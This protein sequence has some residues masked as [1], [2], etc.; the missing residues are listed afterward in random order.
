MAVKGELSINN[1]KGLLLSHHPCS[2]PSDPE[3]FVD[4]EQQWS[5][6]SAGLCRALWLCPLLHAPSPSWSWRRLWL[7]GCAQP[8]G[9]PHGTDTYGQPF[10]GT[11]NGRGDQWLWYQCWSRPQVLQHSCAAYEGQGTQCSHLLGY[12]MSQPSFTLPPYGLFLEQP[13]ASTVGE[14]GVFLRALMITQVKWTGRDCGDNSGQCNQ[15]NNCD[16]D[17]QQMLKVREIQRCDLDVT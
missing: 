4:W 12:M 17:N 13:S 6:S 15:D 1:R 2:S 9:Q 8:R 14:E 5:I 16:C 11:R 7:P 3:P 10:W